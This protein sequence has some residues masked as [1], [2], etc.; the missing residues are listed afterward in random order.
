[1]LFGTDKQGIVPQC[2]GCAHVT[3]SGENKYC[4]AYSNPA[5]KWMAG[6][7]NLGTHVQRKLGGETKKVN[8]LKASK[9]AMKGKA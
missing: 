2:E 1:M 3:A 7:C 5:A 8:P 4:N 6:S 9:K